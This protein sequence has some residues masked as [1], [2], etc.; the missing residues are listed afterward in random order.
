VTATL[1]VVSAPDPTGLDELAGATD[2][3]L[4]VVKRAGRGSRPERRAGT[5][6]LRRRAAS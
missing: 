4:Y 6:K 3:R 1:G 5:W 2:E